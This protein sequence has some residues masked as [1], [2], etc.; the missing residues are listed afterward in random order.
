MSELRRRGV[1]TS[2]CV[3]VA[4]LMQ[5]CHRSQATDTQSIAYYMAIVGSTLLADKTRTGMRPHAILAVNVD[6]DEIAWG[7]VTLAYMY[8]QLGMASRAGCNTIAG[9]LTLLQTWIY[10][11]FPAFRPHPRRADV[12]NKTRAEMWSTPKPSR[13]INSVTIRFK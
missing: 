7:T 5:L 6:Q 13:E 9:C 1:F 4:E 12:P 10:E 2:G 8:R 11:Y 3:N